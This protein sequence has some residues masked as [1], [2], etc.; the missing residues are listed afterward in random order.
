MKHTTTQI[1]QNG[2]VTISSRIMKLLFSVTDSSVTGT[3][4]IDLDALRSS[5]KVEV[6]ST[7][8]SYGTKTIIYQNS[9]VDLMEIASANEGAVRVTLGNVKG[10][11]ELSDEGA[12]VP[13]ENEIFTV[14]VTSG[15]SNYKVDVYS[16]DHDTDSQMHLEYTPVSVQANAPT[17]VNVMSARWLSVPKSLLTQLELELPTGQKVTYSPDELEQICSEANEQSYII[18]GVI[19]PG[20]KYLLS[21]NVADSVRAYITQSAVGNVYVVN[22]KH[23]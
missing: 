8:P 15:S 5:M 6:K 14:N 1:T 20:G 23:I 2:S 21:I 19:V 4:K 16:I 17:P 18:D 10:T 11:I 22:N 9:L 13:L 12:I 3:A 7:H